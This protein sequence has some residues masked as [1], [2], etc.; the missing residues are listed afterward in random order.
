MLG[1]IGIEF[2]RT[3][4]EQAAPGNFSSEASWIQLRQRSESDADTHPDQVGGIEIL[5]VAAR[6][7]R[8]V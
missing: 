4:A 7:G 3:R 8:L 5:Q 6:V 1:S 2:P